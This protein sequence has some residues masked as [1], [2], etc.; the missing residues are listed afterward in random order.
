MDGWV[1]VRMT[2]SRGGYLSDFG[3]IRVSAEPLLVVEKDAKRENDLCG[4]Q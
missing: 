3:L 2:S 1:I 4:W